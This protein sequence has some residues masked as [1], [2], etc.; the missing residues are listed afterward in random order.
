MF[1][2][3]FD[4]IRS[5]NMTLDEVTFE[6]TAEKE[7][8]QLIYLTSYISDKTFMPHRESCMTLS[9]PKDFS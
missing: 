6:L 5:C 9:I 2:N 1:D 8:S 7:L 3:V 4:D